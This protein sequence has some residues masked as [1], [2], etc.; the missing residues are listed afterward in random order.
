M[1]NEE[2]KKYLNKFF[3][4]K[5]AFQYAGPKSLFKYRTFDAFAFDMFENK[6]LY[7]CP[8]EKED[9]K[10]ECDVSFDINDYYDIQNDK[11]RPKAIDLIFQQ[12]EPHTS[13]ENM[14]KA[15]GIISVAITKDGVVS[16]SILLQRVMDCQYFGLIPPEDC[17]NLVNWLAN[18]PK[19]LNDPEIKSQIEKLFVIG[20]NA[21]RDTGICSL[22]ESG[23]DA[24][25]WER[26][27]G[28]GTGYCVEYDVSDYAYNV[29][30]FPVI[31]DDQR[32]NNIVMQIVGNCIGQLITDFSHREIDA[33]KTQFIRLFLTKNTEWEYQKEWRLLGG[34]GVKMPAPTIKRV[35]L[36]KNIT[37]ENKQ[38]MIQY[39][40]KNK[41]E[42]AVLKG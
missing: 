19:R 22:C 18:I 34:A 25:M 40:D 27:A 10:T 16:R 17:T 11:L 23:N 14:A 38:K 13:K 41:I 28:N 37:A 8:A 35:Y 31:Y 3:N 15:K 7:L 4:E 20:Y 36:G 32:E 9:D 42:V 30:I 1:T 5:E 33:D 2:K 24:E 21:K 26:Y 12:V 29:G 6:Y 39:A